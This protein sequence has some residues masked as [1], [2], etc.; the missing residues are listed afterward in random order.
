MLENCATSRCH[1]APGPA[2]WRIYTGRRL[3]SNQVYTNFLLMHEFAVGTERLIDRD[4]PE[5]S[6]LLRFGLPRADE[7]TSDHPSNHPRDI[8]P[9]F[10]DTRDKKYRRILDWIETLSI[11]TPDYGIRL[12]RSAASP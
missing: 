6:T 12:D 2:H 4:F 3:S 7:L 8:E 5:R 9:A 1:A 11:P 10:K